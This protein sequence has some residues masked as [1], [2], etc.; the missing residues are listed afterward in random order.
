MFA[1]SYAGSTFES[2]LEVAIEK[3]MALKLELDQWPSYDEL[4]EVEMQLE[5][6]VSAQQQQLAVWSERLNRALVIESDYKRSNFINKFGQSTVSIDIAA[7]TNTATKGVLSD[8]VDSMATARTDAL[9]QIKAT[10]HSADLEEA[11]QPIR[12]KEAT[13]LPAGGTA[14]ACVSQVLN[15]LQ[16]VLIIHVQ[17]YY[18]YYY[19]MCVPI[20]AHQLE[21]MQSL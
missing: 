19:Y 3:E 2:E 9:A 16:G 11:L 8:K 14:S 7:S 5:A 21:V 18:L 10:D 4:D 1:G 6:A 17:W 13:L 12:G 20:N 15:A